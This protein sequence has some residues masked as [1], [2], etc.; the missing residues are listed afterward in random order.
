MPSASV[1]QEIHMKVNVALACAWA[2]IQVSGWAQS[3]ATE[4]DGQAW[5]R[6]NAAVGQ[7][8]RGHADILAQEAA[9]AKVAGQRASAAGP[10]LSLRQA[11]TMALRQRPD[12]WLGPA[13]NA[14]EIARI[15][16]QVA[17]LSHQV[18]RAWVEA[19]AANQSVVYLQDA[20]EAA[21]AGAEL[22]QRMAAVGNWSQMQR[23][24]TQLLQSDAA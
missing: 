23:V 24:Q 2:C 20:L 21:E 13:F 5:R 7:H 22:A 16:A 19:V 12:L 9:Q 15:N 3:T 18:S 1:T 8:Q 14:L 6:A 17:Q 11:T 4:P 10:V